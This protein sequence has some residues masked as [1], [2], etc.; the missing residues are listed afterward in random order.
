[1]RNI[2]KL[3]SRSSKIVHIFGALCIRI[4]PRFLSSSS[5]K[6]KILVKNSTNFY[7]G[8]FHFSKKSES[9]LNSENKE[10][11]LE[12]LLISKIELRSHK[13]LLRDVTNFL[14]SRGPY[15]KQITNKLFITISPIQCSSNI[16]CSPK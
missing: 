8:S 9:K 11:L 5:Q 7:T 3:L 2:L 6:W 1:M 14:V 12:L 16:I 15:L 10:G 4:L 13:T